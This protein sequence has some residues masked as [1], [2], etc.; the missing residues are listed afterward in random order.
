[1]TLK[2]RQMTG[3]LQTYNILS[4]AWMFSRRVKNLNLPLNYC[5]SLFGASLWRVCRKSMVIV[6]NLYDNL[7]CGASLSPFKSS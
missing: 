5:V 4:I 7:D 6:A 2:Y 3:Q 1:M